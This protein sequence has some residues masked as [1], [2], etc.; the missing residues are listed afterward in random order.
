VLPR[1]VFLLS[2]APTGASASYAAGNGH[3][4]LLRRRRIIDLPQNG[5]NVEFG[6]QRREDPI[7]ERIVLELR[8][9]RV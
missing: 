8:V 5:N 7:L 6:T 1:P 3:L 9:S 4:D 2:F